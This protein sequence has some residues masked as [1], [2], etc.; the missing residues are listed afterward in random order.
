MFLEAVSEFDGAL[1]FVEKRIA[2]P[3]FMT[4]GVSDLEILLPERFISHEFWEEP[5]KVAHLYDLYL[6]FSKGGSG[7]GG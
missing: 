3:H 5:S 2:F 1:F 4:E 7:G 6:G